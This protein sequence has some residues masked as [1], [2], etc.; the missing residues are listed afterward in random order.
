MMQNK[1]KAEL[2][3]KH[4]YSHPSKNGCIRIKIVGIINTIA[5][6]KARLCAEKLCQHLPFKFSSPQIIEMFQT[7]WHEY[8]I[9][10][11]RQIG[12]R[13]WSLAQAVAVFINDEFL[14]S[15][16]EL[17]RYLSR[18]Y[19]FSLPVGAEYYENRAMESCKKFIEKS[20]RKYVYFT[21]STHHSIIG[22][23]VF[24]LYSD[25]LPLTCQHFLNLCTGYDERKQCYKDPYYINTYVHRIVKNGWIQCGDL[26]LFETDKDDINDVIIIPDE[27][28]CIP[29][30]RQGV[31]SM[32]NDGK[33]HNQSQF[34]VCL[35]PNPWMNHFY[36]A[37]GQ[38][39][40]G[41]RALKKLENMSTYYEQ[42]VKEIIVSQCG[43][44]V[45]GDEIK[46]ETESK[47]F[48]EHQSPAS[49]EGE[50][51][52]DIDTFDFYSIT[53]WLDNIVDTIDVRDTASLLMT[54]RYLNGLYCLASDYKSGMDMRIYEKV[55]IVGTTKYDT[56]AKLYDLLLNF[57]PDT[58]NEDEKMSFISEISKIILAYVLYYE[59]NEFCLN[60]ISMHT[61]ATIHQILEIA[62]EITLKAIER[63][64]RNYISRACGDLEIEKIFE[65]KHFK[66]VLVS[67]DCM[68]LLEEIITKAILC[69]MRT[70]EMQE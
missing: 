67:E 69:L 34:T 16:V 24:M 27:S 51:V 36:V 50:Y 10:M 2:L 44:Y 39:I 22:S 54:E 62:H 48:L 7:D 8:I 53:P 68:L 38:L 70:F 21:L 45:F 3:G 61:H 29:H 11:K 32:A 31:L 26:E 1:N 63:D 19:I 13:M 17:L 9:K 43:E 15:D 23:L 41:V 52:G 4:C 37:F 20:K 14:G 49:M 46:M 65:E 12:G 57:H 25:L 58:M 64:K 30:D 59:H 47:I 60:H 42:P 28:Y 56:T 40:D 66:N 18:D 5:F 35:K 55:D 6:Q 33:H